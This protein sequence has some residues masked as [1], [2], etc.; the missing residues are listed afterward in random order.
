MEELKKVYEES[1]QITDDIL[2]ALHFVCG[3]ALVPALDLVE[4]RTV[5]LLKSPS[6]RSLYQVFGSSG[7]PYTCFTTSLYC[8][9]PAY[10]FAVLKRRDNL[11]CK[12][13]LAIRLSEALGCI[14]EQ[15]ISD[16]ELGSAIR[17]M[18]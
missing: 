1:G 4:R 2:S 12:H 13:V 11:M 16:K 8:T 7:V 6:G 10:K 9:C 3:P 14:K 5:S 18:D 17:C 15:A